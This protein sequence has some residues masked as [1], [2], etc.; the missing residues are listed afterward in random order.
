MGKNLSGFGA[1]I[2]LVVLTYCIIF[3]AITQISVLSGAT[4]LIRTDKNVHVVKT[5]ESNTFKVYSSV[6]TIEI[7]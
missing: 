5:F 2:V 3:T 7:K 1:F 4:E 6:R